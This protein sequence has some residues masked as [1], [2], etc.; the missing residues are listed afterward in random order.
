[1]DYAQKNH[2][3]LIAFFTPIAIW[4]ISIGLAVS[5][6]ASGSPVLFTGIVYDL[7]LIAPLAYLALIW[8]TEIKRITA[9]PVFII[10]LV[11]ANIITPEQQNYHL[12]II[13]N[14]L[15]PVV[16]LGV[17]SFII[18]KVRKMINAFK[19]NN[20]TSDFLITLQLSAIEVLQSK[21]IG[22]IFTTEI[23]MIYYALFAWKRPK[24]EANQF[25]SYRENGIIAI[26]IAIT[27]VLIAET[28]G[29]HFLLMK[30]NA[31]VAWVI[32]GL[33]IYTGIQLIGHTK[34]MLHRFTEITATKLHI[35]YGLFGDTQIDYD[36]I[37][38]I[39]QS[40][41]NVED[42]KVQ[43]IGLLGEMEGHNIIIY[44][45]EKVTITKAY[46]LTKKADIIMLHLDNKQEF[47]HQ[48]EEKTQS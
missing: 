16:E 5:S 3:K 17:I 20:E 10:G 2:L 23:G 39:E 26:Y 24:I 47:I 8:N 27:F 42:K 25:S 18:I 38:R 11:I 40:T 43:K 48:I 14:Y 7:T 4:L 15:L 19:Q 44:L 21:K 34:S 28:V 22:M 9:V 12:T 45:R 33:S 6:L 46:G 36:N 31:I 32:F 41:N 29:L 1:M 35:K 30:W 37:Q 13:S